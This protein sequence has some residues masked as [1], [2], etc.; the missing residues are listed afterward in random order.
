LKAL[1]PG[2]VPW[3]PSSVPCVPSTYQVDAPAAGIGV[4]NTV[5]NAS[6]SA[7]MTHTEEAC[8][9][10]DLDIFCLILIFPASGYKIF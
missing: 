4:I 6:I 9:T 3:E 1:V 5:P 10:I 2:P 7:K 8:Q